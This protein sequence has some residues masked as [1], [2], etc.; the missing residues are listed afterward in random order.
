MYTTR[1]H[2][3][4]LQE[5]RLSKNSKISKFVS[6]DTIRLDRP[7]AKKAA[8]GIAFLVLNTISYNIKSLTPFPNGKL[9]IQCITI[10]QDNKSIDIVNIYDND[11]S[12][13]TEEFNHYFKQINKEF[14]I[15][16]DFNGHHHRWEP[17]KNPVPNTCGRSIVK[18][19]EE[20][21]N[22]CLITPPRLTHICKH[23]HS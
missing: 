15:V 14:M 7:I 12:L 16:G 17:T 2:I 20:H 11:G 6:Y 19:L 8:G 13:K 18:L 23:I 1:P 22:L 9:E 4:A 10:K 5:T 21:E 3:V